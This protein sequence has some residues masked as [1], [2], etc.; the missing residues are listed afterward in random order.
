MEIP[1]KVSSKTTNLIGMI[2]Y[3]F[4]ATAGLIIR[5]RAT[6][7]LRGSRYDA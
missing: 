3:S 5:P 2:P 7:R 4:T 6:E 1:S